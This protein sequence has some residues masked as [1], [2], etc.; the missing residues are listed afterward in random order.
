MRRSCALMRPVLSTGCW[1]DALSSEADAWP[2]SV[3]ESAVELPDGS[4]VGFIADAGAVSRVD[5][6]EDELENDL[7]EAE[8]P[9]EA[10]AEAEAEAAES[11]RDEAAGH[12]VDESGDESSASS[13]PALPER[14]LR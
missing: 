9:P 14:S 2:D 4:G 8:L 10:A 13:S 12:R 3:D 5:E 6:E 7:L 11:T 1:S